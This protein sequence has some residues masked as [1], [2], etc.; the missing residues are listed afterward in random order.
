MNKDIYED[1]EELPNPEQKTYLGSQTA[2]SIILDDVA[3]PKTLIHRPQDDQSFRG[4]FVDLFMLNTVGQLMDRYK[5][6][7]ETGDF[8][9]NYEPMMDIEGYEP[10]YKQFIESKNSIHTQIIKDQIDRNNARRERTADAGFFTHLG[11][12]IIDPVVLIPIFGVKGVGLV[13]NFMRTAGQIGAAEVP[14]QY[15]RYNLDPTMTK[16][17]GVATVGYSMLFGGALGSAVGALKKTMPEDA[18][19]KSFNGKSM[20][21]HIEKY[22]EGYNKATVKFNVGE[23]TFNL[24]PTNAV[25]GI[26]F[27]KMSGKKGFNNPSKSVTGKGKRPAKINV[28]SN[29]DLDSNNTIYTKEQIKGLLNNTSYRRA[30]Y[31]REVATFSKVADYDVKANILNFDER[32]AKGQ[33][34]NKLYLDQ[35]RKLKVKLPEGMLKTEE[36]WFHF[37]A[38]RAIGEKVYKPRTKQFK[39]DIGYQKALTEWTIDYVQKPVNANYKTDVGVLLGTLEKASPL[40]RGLENIYKNKKM[41][42][43]D[44]SYYARKLYEITGNHGTILEANRLGVHSPSSIAM[45]LSVKHFARYLQHIAKIEDEFHKLYGFDESMSNM[46]RRGKGFVIATKNATKKIGNFFARNKTATPRNM[47][48][49]EFFELVGEARLD[50]SILTR[51]TGQEKKAVTNALKEVNQFFKFYNTEA[52]RLG[53]FATQ[54]T[55]TQLL[56]KFEFARDEIN[57]DLGATLTAQIDDFLKQKREEFFTQGTRSDPMAF[58]TER[59]GI[60]NKLSAKKKAQVKKKLELERDINF[61]ERDVPNLPSKESTI[62]D[63]MPL[64]FNHEK[65]KKNEIAFKDMLQ[66]NLEELIE[67]A[68]APGTKYLIMRKRLREEGYPDK[69][70]NIS[71]FEGDD[72]PANERQEIIRAEV[73]RRYTYVLENQSKFQDIEGINNIDRTYTGAGKIGSKNLLARETDIPASEFAPFVETDIN[74][75]MRSYSQRMGGAIEFTRRYGDTHMKDFLNHLEI[76]MIRAGFDKTEMNKVINSFQDEKDKLLGTFYSADPTALT[77]RGVVALR[78][79]ISLAYMGKVALSALPEAGR[80]VMVNGFQKTF[81]MGLN[82]LFDAQNGFAKSNLKDIR[83]FAPFQELAVAMTNRYVYEGGITLDATRSGRIFDKYFGQYA[84]RAQEYFFTF[85]GL[86][87]MTYYYK[88][89]NSMISI[90]RFLEDSI[91]WSKGKLSKAE[92]D[93]L[94][95]YG[96]DKE[97]AK[98]IARMPIEKIK[99][100]DPNLPGLLANMTEWHKYDGG[101]VARDVLS[102]AIKTD[103]DRA[104]VTPTAGDAPN[105]MS[106]VI[107]IND[108]GITQLFENKLFRKFIEIISVGTVDRTQFGVKIN[109]APLQLLTQ[110][111]SWAFGA[112]GKVLISATQGREAGANMWAGMSTMIGL[113][114]FADWAKNPQYW[115]NKETTEKIIRGVELSGTMALLGDLNFTMETMSGGITGQ[116]VGLRPLLG[117]E[118][119]FGDADEHDAFT[120]IIGAGPAALYDL[121]RALGGSEFTNEEKHD[122]IKRLIPLSNTYIIGNM[123]ENIYDSIRGVQ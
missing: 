43:D 55:Q 10:N 38:V 34:I 107:R 85:N 57:N 122:T 68:P 70:F 63:Y 108:E 81:R 76:K 60:M 13:K 121:T 109:S 3:Q 50:N 54:G 46:Q 93:R 32:V 105:M 80:P 1:A 52:S 67:Q 77:A 104:I 94:L 90:H 31:E 37:N 20:T 100:D 65:V 73:E 27:K 21:E 75:V 14:N 30:K 28:T 47:S 116:S 102:K 112:N 123:I 88:T 69:G 89:F 64:V 110:F 17:E 6:G 41:N 18:Y 95:S 83:Y 36:D 35:F 87:P 11:A 19:A 7:K 117:V 118:P 78:N 56:R 59:V 44:K 99:T 92:Q 103:V 111:Y 115:E 25:S 71:K 101:I 53:M 8:D 82:N 86:Q 114:M 106:G 45:D 12:G 49:V 96:I 22:N 26:V 16:S 29:L 58:M 97:M 24:D 91:K 84:E 5:F 9:P 79:M 119:R 40:R 23:T 72:V 48:K 2:E 62:K 33:W 74:F 61:A 120:S 113:G 66:R 15:L 4:D 98:V 42:D 39:T 51:L